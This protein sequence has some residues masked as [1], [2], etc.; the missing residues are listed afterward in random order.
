MPRT[1]RGRVPGL[2]LHLD[3]VLGSTPRPPAWLPEPRRVD[4]VRIGSS[5]CPRLLP[6]PDRLRHAADMAIS[7]C[8]RLELETPPLG[9][10]DLD[11]LRQLLDQLERTR[12]GAEVVVNDWGMLRVVHREYPL[13][14]P[15]IGRVLHRQM[16][17]PRIP[18][19]DPDRLGGRPPAWGLGSATSR[20]WARL[21]RRWGVQRVEI[22]WPLHGLEPSAWAALDLELTLHLPLTLVASGRSCVLRDPL[23]AVDRADHGER[24]D[25]SCT[26]TAIHLEAPWGDRAGGEARPEMVRLGNAELARLPGQTLEAALDWVDAGGPDRIAVFPEG[27]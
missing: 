14:V 22:D 19:V 8:A 11:R 7:M 12:P 4:R 3:A 15:V 5:L 10:G 25:L 6:P 20:G 9:D 16:C 2:S 1:W 24:C 13:L 27:P 17:D 18:A 26:H 21:V 23:G